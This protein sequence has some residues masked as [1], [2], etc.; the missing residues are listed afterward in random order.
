MQPLCDVIVDASGEL[1]LKISGD[2][3][4]PQRA[5]QLLETLE[6]L[7]GFGAP[8]FVDVEDLGETS[9]Q[10]QALLRQL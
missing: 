3:N 6:G 1:R 2:W 7:A 10:V 9:E 5:R 4:E 8:S